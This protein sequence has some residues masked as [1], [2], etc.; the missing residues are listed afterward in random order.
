MRH[1]H[2]VIACLC[3]VYMGV[4]LRAHPN[5]GELLIQRNTNSEIATLF[6]VLTVGSS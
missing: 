1:D 4:I 2:S 3:H 6:N 5:H